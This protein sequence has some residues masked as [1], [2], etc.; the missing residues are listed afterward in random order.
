V[1]PG[2]T[3]S[4][5]AMAHGK[6]KARLSGLR[7]V[8]LC[9]VGCVQRRTI[10]SHCSTPSHRFTH[11]PLPA[12]IRAGSTW[13]SDTSAF[14]GPQKS[15]D[16]IQILVN[17]EQF[18]DIT[19]ILLLADSITLAYSAVDGF[20]WGSGVSGVYQLNVTGPS[21]GVE[22]I[23]TLFRDINFEIH[24]AYSLVASDGTY[25][26]AT[27]T[28]VQGYHNE[29]PFDWTTPI[30]LTKEYFVP[31]LAEDEHLVGLTMTFDSPGEKAFLVFSTTRGQV[32]AVAVDFQTASPLFQIPGIDTVALPSAFVNNPIALDGPEG[33]IYVATSKSMVRL[34]WNPTAITV[35]ADWLTDYGNGDDDWMWGRVGPGCGSSPTLMGPT[36]G[37][38]E[39]VVITDG[40]NPMNIRFY[41]VTDG[42]EVG[43]HVVTFGG[44]TGGN[45]TTEQSVVVWGYRAVVVN[46]YVASKVT[47]TCSEFFA[48]LNVSDALKHECPFLF[49][50]FVN[51]IEQFELD[52]ATGLVTSSWANP[53]VSCTSV[54]PVVSTVDGILYCVGKRARPKKRDIFTMEAVDWA[55]GQSLYHVET[56]SSLL[57]NGLYAGTIIGTSGD[58]VMGN[59][60]GVT[61]WSS[62]AAPQSSVFK[63]ASDEESAPSRSGTSDESSDSPKP[64]PESTTDGFK[65]SDPR[66]A[67]AAR[68]LDQLVTWYEAGHSPSEAELAAVGLAVPGATR[69]RPG[70]G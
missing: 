56:S 26:C 65:R 48:A 61:R 57:A 20:V 4:N 24:G 51:G 6:Q 21:T 45:S 66:T 42:R 54:V 43:K 40:E 55:T 35:S 30:E 70:L 64:S 34:Q 8:F 10:P 5:W 22:V 2:L 52:P 37:V 16:E 15:D 29:V 60:A 39:F 14:P 49:G 46:N 53:N 32:G 18:S 31:G 36:G 44:A 13:A 28:S 12:F 27:K 9:C 62:S 63:G 59:M 68:A 69:G 23:N 50:A 3:Q 1:P 47:T 38:A 41:S 11:H 25:F 67:A 7:H 19:D 33:G 58:I 17:G